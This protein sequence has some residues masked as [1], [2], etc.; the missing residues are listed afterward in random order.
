MHH[1]CK[2]DA[3]KVSFFALLYPL[4]EFTGSAKSYIFYNDQG[5]NTTCLIIALG[6]FTLAQQPIPLF[7]IRASIAEKMGFEP[8]PELSSGLI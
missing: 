4:P 7:R 5:N 6:F 1:G 8:M 2:E 3:E